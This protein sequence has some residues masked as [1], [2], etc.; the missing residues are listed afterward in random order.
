MPRKYVYQDYND[1]QKQKQLF[2]ILYIQINMSGMW[3]V[4]PITPAL[5]EAEAGGSSQTQ[6]YLRLQ[7]KTLPPNINKIKC[8]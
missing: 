5:S 2:T 8:I 3:Q 4:M 1:S 6:D 7:G